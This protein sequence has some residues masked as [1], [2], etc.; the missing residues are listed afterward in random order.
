RHRGVREDL[1]T[2][3]RRSVA[4]FAQDRLDRA[5]IG[6]KR[7]YARR[8]EMP[9]ALLLEE[10]DAFVERPRTLVRALRNERVEH[11]GHGDDA[12]DER[13]VLA[14]QSVRITAAVEFFVMAE[15]D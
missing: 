5:A 13:D 8:V 14:V 7:V 6:E 9:P 15:R 10:F 1:E 11:V 4:E 2:V 12:R 3:W